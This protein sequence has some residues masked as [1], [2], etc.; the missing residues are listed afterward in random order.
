MRRRTTAAT[1]GPD[2]VDPEARFVVAGRMGAAVVLSE[3]L[4]VLVVL[5]AVD[6]VLDAIGTRTRS[7]GGPA[8]TSCRTSMGRSTSRTYQEFL[9]EHNRGRTDSDGRPDRPDE[10][11]RPA[12]GRGA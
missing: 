9:Q 5:P 11:S 8:S 4:D 1:A 12:A 6:L 7:A 10:R 2:D 3:Q